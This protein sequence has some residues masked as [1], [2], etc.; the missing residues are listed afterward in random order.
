MVEILAAAV[1]GLP[2]C[3]VAASIASTQSFVE[4][5]GISTGFTQ[6]LAVSFL[7]ALIGFLHAAAADCISSRCPSQHDDT[8]PRLTEGQESWLCKTESDVLEGDMRTSN[9]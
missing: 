8:I 2:R 9:T 3:T 6:S 5:S 7:L 4:S 1:L